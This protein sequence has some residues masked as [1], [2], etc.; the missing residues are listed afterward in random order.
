MIIC[1]IN[2]FILLLPG[3]IYVI[4]MFSVSSRSKR[5]QTRLDI[6]KLNPSVS[7]ENPCKLRSTIL[8]KFATTAS[9]RVSW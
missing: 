8:T 7:Y 5:Q 9:S 3:K 1:Y 6:S 2:T 4:K